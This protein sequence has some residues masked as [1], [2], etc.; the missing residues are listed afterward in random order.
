MVKKKKTTTDKKHK[1][2]PVLH[3]KRSLKQRVI[4]WP[5][6][7]RKR[8]HNLLLRRP[9]RSFK[10]TYRRDYIRSLKLP[11]Y[12]SFTLGVFKT[13]WRHK[14]MFLLLIFIY[15]I[16]T[17]AVV[18]I[19]SQTTYSEYSDTLRESGGKLF[20]GSWWEVGQA[21][22]LLTTGILGSLDDAPG[23]LERSVAILLGL[24]IWLTTVWL[25]RA[26]M[27]GEK[28]KLRDGLYNAGAPLISTA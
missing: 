26:I 1:S 28:P 27:A 23:D 9:H 3:Q 18:G 15:A 4:Q 20:T 22:I 16:I 17:A 2:E 8:V 5:A 19:A 10:H 7:I 25:L 13:V 24:M 11:G 12:W 21:G 6:S 14:K